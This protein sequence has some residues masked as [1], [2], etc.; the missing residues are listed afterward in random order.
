MS[1]TDDEVVRRL[2]E[3]KTAYGF[4]NEVADL[5]VHP[6]LRR[7]TVDTP[8]GPASGVAPPVLSGAEPF[9]PR[10]VPGLGAH[11]DA[12]RAEFAEA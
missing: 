3:A 12:L 5:S 7:I 9:V 6:Q 10:A 11:S 8:S 1:L 2:R 4:L